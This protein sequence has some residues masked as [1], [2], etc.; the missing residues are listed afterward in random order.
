MII[1]AENRIGRPCS[2]SSRNY[3][4]WLWT[5]VFKEDMNSFYYLNSEQDS[6]AHTCA[7]VRAHTHTH[8][9]SLSLSLSLTH[10]HTHT[11]TR[12]RAQTHTEVCK[13]SRSHIYARTL[14]HTHIHVRT[15]TQA[16]THTRMH[17]RTL[18][19]SHTHICVCMRAYLCV[20]VCVFFVCKCGVL[21]VYIY[22]YIYICVCVY[23][24]IYIYRERERE[25]D[26]LLY[27]VCTFSIY[28]SI[29]LCWID[30]EY[31]VSNVL[32]YCPFLAHVIIRKKR[33]R[34]SGYIFI[35]CCMEH[36]DMV[37]HSSSFWCLCY[38][39]FLIGSLI[40]PFLFNLQYNS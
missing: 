22:I 40:L 37:Q 18:S 32:D 12:A 39:N 31:T 17:A 14:T 21:C 38:I 25:R 3:L 27:N 9:L 10:T 16:P 33:L 4:H 1:C 26:Q 7:C 13:R 30:N 35:Y 2:C 34:R 11:H 5:N 8:T 29:Y 24:Y 19:L 23:I 28:L 6:Q 20:C 15:Y 36:D